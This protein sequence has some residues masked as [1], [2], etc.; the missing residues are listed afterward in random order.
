MHFIVDTIPGVN[1]TDTDGTKTEVN[2]TV[3]WDAMARR[4]KPQAIH[5]SAGAA[6]EERPP[7]PA[8]EDDEDERKTITIIGAYLPA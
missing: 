7:P 5:Q 4:R 6:A 8:G 1:K 2:G 3:E